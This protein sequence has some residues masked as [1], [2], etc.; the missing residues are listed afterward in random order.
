MRFCRRSRW[1]PVLA[2]LW[3]LG[4]AP[5]AAVADGVEVRK[6]ALVAS[7]KGYYLEAEFDIRLTRTLDGTST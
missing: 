6:A 2:A 3:L 5:V 1:L 7:G 4:G